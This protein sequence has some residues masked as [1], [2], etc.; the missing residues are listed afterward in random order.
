MIN[1]KS[2]AILERGAAPDLWRHTLSHISTVFGRLAYLSSLRELNS[3]K[4]QHHGLAQ[5][6]GDDEADR[7]LRQSHAQTFAEWLCFDLEQ[8]KTDVVNYLAELQ[9]SRRQVIETWLRVS[10]YQSYIPG[11]ATIT[12][13]ELYLSDFGTIMELLKNEYGVDGVDL[14]A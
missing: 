4:Y 2:R 7:A 10:T 8:Q 1:R 13:R 14:D 5:V 6:F 3:G 11:S 9:E 12:Q